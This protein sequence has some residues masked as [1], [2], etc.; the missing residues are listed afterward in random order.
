MSFSSASFEYIQRLVRRRAAIVL[1]SNKAYLVQARL[2]PIVRHHNLGTID[3]L[4]RELQQPHG[5]PLIDD[6]IDAMTT[7]ETFF[8]R[9]AAPFA[10]LRQEVFPRLFQ[11]R[12][13]Q[14]RLTIWSA[15]CS[16][17]QEPYSVA[18]LLREHFP[19]YLD[20]GI[21]LLASDLSRSALRQAEQGRYSEVEMSR[22]LPP[23]LRAK[24]FHQRGSDSVICQEVRSMVEF[25][26][27]NLAVQWP[28]LPRADVVLLRNV[29]VYFDTATK[30]LIL[31]RVRDLMLPDSYLFL[32]GAETTLHLEDAFARV[33]KE[34]FSFFQLRSGD[35]DRSARSLVS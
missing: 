19:Q 32:G 30:K 1:D 29:M 33:V 2:L 4:V 21:R 9:D 11:R 35:A 34:D 24:Y 31:R 23:E 16:T 10:A 26:P 14:K 18:M 15:A 28:A 5:G 20:W 12:A 27:L 13:E 22:G 6:V 7:K 8:F 17:G 3:Q 25:R